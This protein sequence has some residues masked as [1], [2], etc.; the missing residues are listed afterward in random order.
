MEPIIGGYRWIK[1]T[2]EHLNDPIFLEPYGFKVFSQNDEDGILQEIFDRIG[3]TNKKFIEF[4]VQDGIECNSHY[5]L[6]KGW[7]G[8]WIEGYRPYFTQIQEKFSSV[9]DEG[10]LKVDC[11]FITKDNINSL[12]IENGIQGEIDLLSIDIDGNDYYVWDSIFAVSP[13]VVC[14]EYNGKF[15]PDC[16]WVMPYFSAHI[17]HKNDYQG[18]SLKSLEKLGRERGYQLVGTNV[19]GVNAFFVR[20][21]LAGNKFPLPAVAENLYNA[22]NYN[23]PHITGHKSEFCSLRES[24]LARKNDYMYEIQLSG[25]AKREQNAYINMP[26]RSLVYG[27]YTTIPEGE[28]KFVIGI[29]LPDDR[30]PLTGKITAES[31]KQFLKGFLLTDGVTEIDLTLNRQYDD[32]EVVIANR[33]GLPIELKQLYLF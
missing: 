13:R 2:Q 17:W 8:L 3:A 7:S 28:Y 25:G 9:I 29:D 5:L 11:A 31:G 4:G 21:D 1:K 24:T 6:Y 15:P 26:A 22:P 27:P 10:Q 30:I 18:A 14:I 32:V 16:E 20:N 19:T 33:T 12:F 23:L